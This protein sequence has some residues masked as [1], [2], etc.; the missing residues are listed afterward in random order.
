[1]KNIFEILAGTGI[2]VPED[3]KKMLTKEIAANYKTIAE[4]ESKD[5]KAAELQKTID[6]LHEQINVLKKSG[7]GVEELQRKVTAYEE[8][9]NQRKADEQ[10]KLENDALMARFNPL[11]GERAFLNEGTEAW[12]FDKFKK[13]L[14]ADENKGKGDAEIYE[15]ITK[16]QNIYSNPNEKLNVPPAG[17][18]GGKSS[19]AEDEEVRRIMGLPIKKKE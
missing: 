4:F 16:N 12:I 10:A 6:E 2:E 9:E 1:M 8:A 19:E 18:G 5:G 13:A 17:N 11:K 14:Q 15:A 3:K 7:E